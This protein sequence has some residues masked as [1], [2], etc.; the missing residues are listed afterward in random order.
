MF[1]LELQQS[2]VTDTVLVDA[3]QASRH[4]FLFLAPEH[5]IIS[6]CFL[7]LCV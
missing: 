7:P 3:K 5:N 1:H 6:T 4:M 2:L